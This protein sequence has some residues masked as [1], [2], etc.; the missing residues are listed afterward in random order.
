MT[1]VQPD[2]ELAGR[3]GRN[4]IEIPVMI[5]VALDDTDNG[6]FQV[7]RRRR[8]GQA[9]RYA[10]GACALLNLRNVNST[11]TVEIALRALGER[12]RSIRCEFWRVAAWRATSR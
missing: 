4:E 2:Q 9:N 10:S 1:V 5:D 3:R 12:L 7:Y 11:I 6:R 8:S